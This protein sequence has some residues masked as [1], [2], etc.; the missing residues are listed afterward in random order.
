MKMPDP[1]VFIVDDDPAIRDS[2]KFMF[3]GTDI[4]VEF[5]ESAEAFLDKYCT[6]AMGC[7]ILDLRMQGMDGQQLHRKLRSSGACVPVI[8]LT[9][10]GD[11]ATAVSEM[12]FGA[13]DFFT[14]PV[15]R[16]DLLP[17]VRDAINEHVKR[18]AAEQEAIAIYRRLATV[19]ERECEVMDHVALGQ[20]NK[21]IARV[22]NL[23]E[24]TVANHRASVLQKMNAAN[25]ADL[26]RQLGIVGRVQPTLPNSTLP[27]PAHRGKIR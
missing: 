8:I 11:I 19:S 24:R 10:H 7:V 1:K 12:K 6:S 15:S 16:T 3:T 14:K 5:C 26:V 13:F 4:V 27:P 21:Q 22:L 20:S 23:S 17:R 25:T 2:L 18:Y 9:G